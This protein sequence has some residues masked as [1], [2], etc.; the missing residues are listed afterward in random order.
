MV[1]N[2][3]IITWI[4]WN[5]QIL[6]L[7]CCPVHKISLLRTNLT[8]PFR[9]TFG[10]SFKYWYKP[11][12]FS[13]CRYIMSDLPHSALFTVRNIPFTCCI[14]E[15]ICPTLVVLYVVHINIKWPQLLWNKAEHVQINRQS[16]WNDTSWL[17]YFKYKTQSIKFKAL[18]SMA[19]FIW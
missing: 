8:G 15:R 10:Q 9:C 7:H 14:T 6:N 3:L 18:S 11:R 5:Y 19:P 4:I 16:Y 12:R 17:E 1:Q 2:T 13:G